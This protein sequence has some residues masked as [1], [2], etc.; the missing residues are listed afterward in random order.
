MTRRAIA[1]VVAVLA[2][3][4]IFMPLRFALGIAGAGDAGLA[5]VR[6][7]GTVW[8]GRLE[9]ARLG[10]LDLGTL[11]VGLAPLPLPLGRA[12]VDF[13]RVPGAGEPLA[14]SVETGVGRRGFSGLTGS[15]SG[16]DFGG[17]PVDRLVFDDAGALFR[18]GQCREAGGRVTLLLGVRIAGLDL[19]RGLTGDL[20]C[21]GRALVA[22]MAGQSGMERLVLTVDGD[23]GYAARIIIQSTDPLLGVALSA[24]GFAPTAEGFAR[25]LRGRF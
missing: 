9:Q 24:A 6:A 14:G 18:D 23:G 21:E 15:V 8:S 12:R 22:R 1:V 4:I 16:G 5:A 3:A 25:T 7:G 19:R 10:P 13:A 2:A 17:L 20:A 11:D